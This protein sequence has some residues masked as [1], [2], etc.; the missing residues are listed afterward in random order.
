[1]L[2]VSYVNCVLTERSIFFSKPPSEGCAHIVLLSQWHLPFMSAHHSL[3]QLQSNFSI[4][5]K[6]KRIR[7]KTK[8]QE[9]KSCVKVRFVSYIVY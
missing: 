8:K 7:K 6:K 5:V 3:Q 9:K 4:I 1:M 2:F